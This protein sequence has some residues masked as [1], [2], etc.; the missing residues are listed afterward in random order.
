[1]KFDNFHQLVYL[2][3]CFHLYCYIH[4]VSV[5]VS[6]KL[7]QVFRVTLK[8]LHKTSNQTHFLVYGGKLFY[9]HNKEQVLSY[10][11]YY[12][13]FTCGQN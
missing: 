11:K 12:L 5:G 1:M 7:L 13:L 9:F 6:F 3:Y 2:D 10:S 8:S 4:N